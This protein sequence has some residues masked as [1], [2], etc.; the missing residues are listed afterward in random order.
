[1]RK[2]RKTWDNTVNFW[3]VKSRR[4]VSPTFTHLGED[5]VWEGALMAAQWRTDTGT[6]GQ[7]RMTVVQLTAHFQAIS[8]RAGTSIG[9]NYNKI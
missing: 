2:G 8:Q 1:M 5:D 6:V 3:T 4:D 9:I 7:H